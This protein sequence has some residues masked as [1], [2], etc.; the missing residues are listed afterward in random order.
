MVY[1][2]NEGPPM[3]EPSGF[4]YDIVLQGYKAAG[5]NDNILK[6]AVSLAASI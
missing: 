3:T 2:M 1:I 6:K 5:F 4:Y